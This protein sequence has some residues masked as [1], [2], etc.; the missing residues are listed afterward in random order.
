MCCVEPATKGDRMANREGLRQVVIPE[1]LWERLARVA[2]AQSPPSTRP[3][4]IRWL[5]VQGLD[6]IEGAAK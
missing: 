3:A 6:R 1:D 4:L 2:A 5:L